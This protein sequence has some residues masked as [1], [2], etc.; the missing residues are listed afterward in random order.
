MNRK[1]V[2]NSFYLSEPKV[3]LDEDTRRVESRKHREE[4]EETTIK[5]TNLK[6]KD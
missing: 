5:K 4:E 3:M 6:R 2:V 1:F